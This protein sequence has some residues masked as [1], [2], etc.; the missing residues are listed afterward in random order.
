MKIPAKIAF[1][2]RYSREGIWGALGSLDQ[3]VS[4]ESDMV[5]TCGTKRRNVGER[6]GE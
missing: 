5:Q 1:S 3:G 4:A 2:E 6:R